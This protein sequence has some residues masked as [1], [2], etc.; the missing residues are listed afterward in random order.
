MTDLYPPVPLRRVAVIGAGWLGGYLAG[1]LVK[2]GPVSATYRKPDLRDA[3]ESAGVEPVFADF[4]THLDYLPDLFAACDAAVVCLPPGGRTHGEETTARYLSLLKPL[5]PFLT[6]VH[7]VYTSSTGVYGRAATGPVAETSPLRPDTPSSRAVAAAET[8]FLEHA[9]RCTIL[10]L[11]GLYGPGRDPVRFF[12]RQPAI[13]DADA[14][15]NMIGREE[16]VE[17]IQFVLKFGIPGIFN[18]CSASHPTKREFYG[19]RYEE[20]GLPPK[21]FLPGGSERKRIDSSKLRHL[22]WLT[23]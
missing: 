8:F 22:G 21:P 16:A 5:R 15:V 12:A 11:A 4:P 18:V 9:S 20:A 2:S 14:P 19:R 23:P 13:P 6:G 10:R 1:Q 3:L 7:L 17:A